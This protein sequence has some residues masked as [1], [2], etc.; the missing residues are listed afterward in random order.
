MAV[1]YISAWTNVCDNGSSW[2]RL[3]VLRWLLFHIYILYANRGKLHLRHIKYPWSLS[4]CFA[5]AY[6]RDYISHMTFLDFLQAQF[7]RRYLITRRSWVTVARHKLKCLNI[8]HLPS[9]KWLF[10]HS[11]EPS[12]HETL[13]QCWANVSPPSTTLANISPTLVQ[14]L[15]TAE[16]CLQCWTQFHHRPIITA[17]WLNMIFFSRLRPYYISN[18]VKLKDLDFL[19]FHRAGWY[20]EVWERESSIT[21]FSPSDVTAFHR[22]KDGEGGII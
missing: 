12:K 5:V 9:S 21:L 18:F 14:R 8:S 7:K 17:M 13:T 1:L 10:W 20:N 19:C 6:R 15:V 16:K 22:M 3:N 2:D 11:E 4:K